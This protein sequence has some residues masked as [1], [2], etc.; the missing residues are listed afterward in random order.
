MEIT[1]VDDILPEIT[2]QLSEKASREAMN[3][4][5][6][7][8]VSMTRMLRY[9]PLFIKRAVAGWA[10]GFLGDK[11]FSNTL[12]NLGVVTVPSQMAAHIEKFDFVLS[13]AVTNRASCSMISFENTAVLSVAKYTADPSFEEKLYGLFKEDG[14]EP[15]VKG[16]ELYDH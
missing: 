12:S 14:L 7:A 5:L 3:E 10:Y 11:V 6:N 4:M 16:S 8:T 15:K 13:T 9:V 2:C 1:G